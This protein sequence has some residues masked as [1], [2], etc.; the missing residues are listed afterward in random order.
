[1]RN[2][3]LLLM[4]TCVM[5][6]GFSQDFTGIKI[7]VNPGHGGHDSDDRHVLPMDFWESESNLTKGLYLRDILEDAGATVVMSRVTNTT[8]DDLPLSQIS[9]IA[10]DNDVDYFHSIHS[11]AANGKVNYTL[12]LYNGSNGN[13]DIDGSIEMGK[14]IWPMLY[15][16][17]PAW[18]HHTEYVRADNDFLGFNLG[19]L[20]YLTMPHTLTEGS[21]HDYPMETWRLMNIEYRKHEAIIFA[22]A[23]AEWFEL[24][25]KFPHG[26]ISGIVRDKNLKPDYYY[27]NETDDKYAP[28]DSITVEILNEGKVYK[29]DGLHNGYFFFDSIAPGDYTIVTSAN[30]YLNDTMQITV[31]PHKTTMS[32]IYME[33]DPTIPPSI[34]KTSLEYLSGDSINAADEIRVYFHGEMDTEKVENAISISPEAPIEFKWEEDNKTLVIIPSIPYEKKTNYTLTISTDATQV[35]GVPFTENQEIK[36]LTKNRNRLALLD[37]YPQTGQTEIYTE[38]QFHFVFDYPLSQKTLIDNVILSDM[39]GNVIDKRASKIYELE[40]KGV[41]TFQPTEILTPATEYKIHLGG[42]ILDENNNPLFDD[43][44][45]TFTTEA[46]GYWSGNII[47]SFEETGD[48]IDP[49]ASSNTTGIVSDYTY[50]VLVGTIKYTGKKSRKVAYQF[51]NDEGGQI[52][53]ASSAGVNIGKDANSVF[54]IWVYGDMSYHT[55]SFKF[56]DGSR[57]EIDYEYGSVDWSGWKLINFPVS[58]IGGSGDILL[59]SIV[60]IQVPGNFHIGYLYFDDIQND[61]VLPVESPVLQSDFDMQL[62][63]NPVK[64]S[65]VFV[66]NSPE[67]A[68]ISIKIY[69]ING[70]LVNSLAEKQILKGVNHVKWNTNLSEGQYIYS[71]ESQMKS[72]GEKI[73]KNGKF[74]IV[75]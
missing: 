51:S 73:I 7:M 4:F 70:K 45:I 74:L 3:I 31:E 75:Q 25:Q 41:F 58:E 60:L 14:I 9:G 30:E 56:S 71:V 22:R 38:P 37:Y 1:M 61:V 13:D 18:S 16:Y 54:G 40:G 72:N 50:S 34:T 44:D 8:A 59:K 10:N 55:L 43:I 57:G 65:A 12:V 64:E 20:K 47:D 26:V 19:V 49:K 2:Y 46:E 6:L 32:T 17:G 39:D 24:P 33:L 42:E 67:N 5:S 66:I 28:L 23:F 29:G 27:L 68:K 35:F 52:E 63:P 11:N 21:F 15:E 62:V 48:W 53:L 69:D 36:F